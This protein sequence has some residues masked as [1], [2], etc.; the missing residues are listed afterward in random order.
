MNRFLSSA[1]CLASVSSRKLYFS[2]FSKWMKP[3]QANADGWDQAVLNSE[4]L[5]RIKDRPIINPKELLGQDFQ[6]LIDNISRL[7]SSGHP[8]LNTISNYY[9][10]KK[11]KHIRPLMYGNVC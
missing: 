6:L 3:M 2:S 5:I 11:G 8:V 1:N 4:K 10:S 7:L 9:F